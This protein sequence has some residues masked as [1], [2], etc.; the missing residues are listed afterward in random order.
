M[1]VK[2]LNDGGFGPAMKKIEFPVVVDAE[3]DECLQGA[4]LVSVEELIRVGGDRRS[5]IN[6]TLPNLTFAP[7]E[8]EVV[9]E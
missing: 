5:I 2:L 6:T 7:G 4:I 9:D 3:Y 1:K 8:F